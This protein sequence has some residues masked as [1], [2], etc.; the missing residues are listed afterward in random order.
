MNLIIA[1]LENKKMCQSSC[2]NINYLA[3]IQKKCLVYLEDS[4]CQ[5]NILKLAGLVVC[6]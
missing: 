4:V 3:T 2:K 1:I 5:L 6:L